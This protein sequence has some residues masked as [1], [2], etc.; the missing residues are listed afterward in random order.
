MDLIYADVVDNLII[1]RGVLNNFSFDLSYGEDEN[2]FQLVIPM[3]GIRLYEDQV[4]YISGTEYGGIIDAIK[5]DTSAQMITYS[6]RTWHG[7]LESKVLYPMTGNDYMFVSGEANEVLGILLERMNIIPGDLNELYVQPT[8]SI[9]TASTEDSKIY[10]EGKITSKSG[11]YAHG[12]SFIRDLLYQNDAKPVIIDGVISAKPLIDY[13]NSDDFLEGTDQ[14]TAEHKY[15]SLN[16]LHCL[17]SGD[18]RD[19]YTIDLYLSEGGTLLPYSKKNPI[20]DSDYYTDLAALAES[21]DP[22]DIANFAEITANMVTGVKE[23]SDIYDYSNAQLTYHYVIQ[24]TQPEDWDDDLTPDIVD[25]TSKEKMWGFQQYFYQ[26]DAD[27]KYKNV[28]KPAIEYEY[29]LQTSM[30]S[31]WLSNFADYYMS[32]A[33]GYEK[34]SPVTSYSVVGTMPT[35]WYEGAYSNYFK[36]NNGNY[37]KVSLV[38][39]LIPLTD[40]GPDDWDTNWSQYC[41]S[42]GTKVPGVQP[43]TKYTKLTSA[44]A[45]QNWSENYADYYTWDG[46]QYQK[47]KGV[48]KTVWIKLASKPSDW[49]TSYKNYYIKVEGNWVNCT[50]KSQWNINKVRKRGSKTDPPT[51]KKNV[52]YSCYKPPEKAPTFVPG[53]Y[54]SSGKVVPHWGDFTV[55]SKST[56]PTWETNKYYTKKPYQPIPSWANTYYT[57]YEDHY[58]SLIEGALKVIEDSVIK[59][60]LEIKLDENTVYDIND[61][62]GASDEVTGIG[63]VERIVQKVVKINRG[64]VS[65][66]YN[67]GK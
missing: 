38:P 63:A 47:V 34:V 62:V 6:G 4:V 41:K 53:M 59:D 57:Q 39:G 55:Y 28:E 50:K 30:P 42:D 31:D 10:V 66:D 44:K 3:S 52:Y 61:R 11:N 56:I 27:G 33:E 37:T 15:N 29:E 58:Q 60:V 43:A 51:Y 45:P 14:F 9:I 8:N 20:N 12:Y 26:D 18:L 19:R 35:G 1:D 2:D 36:L 49:A 54:F 25:I 64:I 17:G 23:I 67:T 21:T 5:V 40:P 48:S 32:N 16:R 65:F 22:E 24:D 13:S 7:I 46:T